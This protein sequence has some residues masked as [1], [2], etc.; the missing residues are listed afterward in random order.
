DVAG[1]MLDRVPLRIVDYGFAWR[2][3]PVFPQ[4]DVT[5]FLLER[6]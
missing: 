3:D 4:D 5:W 6:T 2:R 1:D